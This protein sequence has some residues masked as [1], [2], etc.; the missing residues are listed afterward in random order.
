LHLSFVI[1]T[2]I[3]LSSK[4]WHCL[5]ASEV[6]G[7]IAP[8]SRLCSSLPSPSVAENKGLVAGAA[9]AAVAIAAVAAAGSQGGLEGAVAGGSSPSSSSSS[10]APAASSGSDS[11][12]PP[13][14]AEAR[15]WIAAWKAK[16]AK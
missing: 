5:A 12:V 16:Q 13:N 3:L 14:V 15:A 7:T 8:P 10:A 1:K 4:R 9:V 11:S 2:L 6:N